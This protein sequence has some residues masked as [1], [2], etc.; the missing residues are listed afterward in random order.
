M[1]EWIGFVITF[2]ALAG[3]LFGNRPAAPKKAAPH[4][5]PS[6]EPSRKKQF[7]APIKRVKPPQPIKPPP[8]KKEYFELEKPP[9]IHLEPIEEVKP[10]SFAEET[11]EKLDPPTDMLIYHEIFGPPK[12]LRRDA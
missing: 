6:G 2:L 5:P 11:L 3:I 7:S 8:K 9:Q 1:V 10:L 4:K 12:G